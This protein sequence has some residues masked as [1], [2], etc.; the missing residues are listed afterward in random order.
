[1][2]TEHL[3]CCRFGEKAVCKHVSAMRQKNHELSALLVS[4]LQAAADIV[5]SKCESC[6]VGLQMRLVMIWD[7]NSKR[8]INI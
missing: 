7:P 2:G 5:N 6:V 8:K 4:T 1:M 3:C